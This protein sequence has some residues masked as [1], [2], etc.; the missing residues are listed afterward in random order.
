MKDI[1][2]LFKETSHQIYDSKV[3]LE[4]KSISDITRLSLMA[5][6]PRAGLRQSVFVCVGLSLQTPSYS[7]HK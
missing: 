5:V 4:S 2:L 3:K 7:A 6:K 1:L